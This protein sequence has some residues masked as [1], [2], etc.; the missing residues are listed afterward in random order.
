VTTH[1]Q[2]RVFRNIVSPYG[3]ALIAYSCFLFSCLLSPTFYT[4][5][6]Q[7]QDLMF[8]D[9]TTILFYTLC[10]I[11]F[12]AGVALF[13]FLFPVIHRN[14]I[15]IKSKIPPALFI[16]IPL[17]I[18]V[19]VCSI[20][21]ALLI[22]R[23]P[24]IL[25]ILLAQ[26]AAQLR[27]PDGSAID[28]GGTFNIAPLFLTGILWWAQ[29]RL[30]NLASLRRKGRTAIKIAIVCGLLASF[31]AS[32]LVVSRHGFVVL[33]MGLGIFYLFRRTQ[34][35]EVRLRHISK[36]ILIFA[37]GGTLFFFLIGILR[38]GVGGGASLL[39]PFLGYTAAS[40]NRLTA[41]LAGRLH[42]EYAAR[43]IYFSSCLSFNH[44]VNAILPYHQIMNLPDYYDW[45]WS[46]FTAVD[47]AG[48]DGSLI[49]VGA[50]G[51][52]FL[53][54]GWFAPLCLLGYGV[55]Y[56]LLWQQIRN[57][58]IIGIILYPYCAYCIL[59][60][61]ATNSLFD[62]D[63]A[64]LLIDVALISGFERLFLRSTQIVGSAPAL[65]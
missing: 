45:W 21:N 48:L 11:S 55:F 62:N 56:G 40:Y 41:L 12:L 39:Q 28:F 20:S 18:A 43:G 61:F 25:P 14:Q 50:F 64:A 3:L 10:V 33:I 51:E 32:T 52:L 9:P 47:H 2:T 65:A 46:A 17:M 53:E 5:C 38:G 7:E 30:W 49:F 26:R 19:A 42:F 6:M 63:F 27:T 15:S 23:N 4:R 29:W 60:W 1:F 35:E 44:T 54:V 13:G 22:K 58:T 34:N 37:A 59:F 57:G 8:M 36:P 16:L 31:V 24:L